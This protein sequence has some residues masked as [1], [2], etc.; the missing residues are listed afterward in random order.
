[1]LMKRFNI[2][3]LLFCL[4]NILFAQNNLNDL[5]LN[6]RTS[7][8]LPYYY[9]T[10]VLNH[11][12][13]DILNLRILDGKMIIKYTMSGDRKKNARGYYIYPEVRD[14]HIFTVE[15]DI[16]K[17]KVRKGKENY[18]NRVWIENNDGII[19]TNEIKDESF[20]E[21]FLMNWFILE[22]N[23]QALRDKLYNEINNS[24]TSYNSKQKKV[25]GFRPKN[26][27]ATPK[28]SKSGRYV[29]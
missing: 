29:E 15:I 11:E 22:A 14:L 26:E 12:V 18:D 16:V 24:F 21:S 19:I 23:S 2:L 4:S 8:E 20:K 10:K 3:L 17:S 7:I 1:M 5:F 25:N 9:K 28:Q 13:A 6:F 27:T